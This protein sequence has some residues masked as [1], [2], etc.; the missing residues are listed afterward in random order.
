M[1]TCLVWLFTLLL[2]LGVAEIV[3]WSAKFGQALEGIGDGSPLVI[4]FSPGGSVQDFRLKALQ[5]KHDRTPV[6]VDGE[7]ASACTLLVDID[8][9]NVCLT[10]NAIFGFHKAALRDPLTGTVLFTSDLFYETPG[11]N[12]YI[13]ARGGLPPPDDLMLADF[14]EMKQF[15]RPC[16]G[17]A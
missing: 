6:I 9:D 11:L 3:G 10:T 12:A 16:K 1:R 15:Y 13:K 2:C 14:T 8:R 17:A 7:C 4:E 5:L